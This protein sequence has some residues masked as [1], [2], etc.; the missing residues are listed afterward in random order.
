MLVSFY[1]CVVGELH[2]ILICGIAKSKLG[3][4]GDLGEGYWLGDFGG[5]D[6]L[7][8]FIVVGYETIWVS[9]ALFFCCGHMF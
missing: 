1:V 4:V 6:C 7:S 2:G 9:E 8:F 3:I 5:E